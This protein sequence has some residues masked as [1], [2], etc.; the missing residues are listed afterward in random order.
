ME[1]LEINCTPEPNEA[2]IRGLERLLEDAR[3]GE[4]QGVA[5]VLTWRD[6]ASGSGYALPTL[7]HGVRAIGEMEWLK[8]RILTGDPAVQD[9]LRDKI[10]Y[11]EPD[12]E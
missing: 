10:L 12:D 7:G 1:L 2:V 11:P 6:G 4:L 5:Y 9:D 8:Q 3:S